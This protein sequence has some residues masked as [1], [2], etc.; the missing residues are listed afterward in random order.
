MIYPARGRRMCL[1]CGKMFNSNGP[2]NRICHACGQLKRD[3]DPLVHQ[4]SW[5]PGT[6][7]S[8]KKDSQ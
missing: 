8:A 1:A 7:L 3:K 5:G 6:S 2:G 4:F